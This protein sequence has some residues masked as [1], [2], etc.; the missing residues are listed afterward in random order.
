M[1]ST[2]TYFFFFF[3]TQNSDTKSWTHP[4]TICHWTLSWLPQHRSLTGAFQILQFFCFF[5]LKPKNLNSGKCFWSLEASKLAIET[6]PEDVPTS[7]MTHPGG[8]SM[9]QWWFSKFIFLFYLSMCRFV[10]QPFVV[11]AKL[12]DRGFIR[13]K[14]ALFFFF[15]L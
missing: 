13:S 10:F 15:F 11:L 14:C 12:F 9:K 1:K 3:G 7:T 8:S 6:A 5:F 4:T 2:H